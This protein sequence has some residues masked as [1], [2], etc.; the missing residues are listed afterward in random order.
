[1]KYRIES[2]F[3]GEMK[4]PSDAYYGIHTQRAVDNFPIA[5]VAI[6]VS[7]YSYSLCNG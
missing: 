2:D 3:L 1:M 7:K 5:D 4:I 6:S